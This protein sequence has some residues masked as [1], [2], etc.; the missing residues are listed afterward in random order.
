MPLFPCTYR[1]AMDP[2]VDIALNFRSGKR[3]GASE[4]LRSL[5]VVDIALNFRSG[6]PDG[7]SESLRSSPV[8]E[9]RS[10]VNFR[11]VEPW[12]AGTGIRD[13]TSFIMVI[14]Y[15]LN[16]LLH[17]THDLVSTV[18]FLSVHIFL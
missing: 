10:M 15:M 14:R 1:L 16:K 7:A 12:D 18:S 4:S 9:I 2:V 6:K 11:S 3:D 5:P 8:S 13:L 17:V